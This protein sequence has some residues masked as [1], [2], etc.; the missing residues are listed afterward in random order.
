MNMKPL[1]RLFIFAAV[2][3]ALASCDSQSGEKP[4]NS[5]P[6]NLLN[7]QLQGQPVS[8]V[9]VSYDGADTTS[10]VRY[11]YNKTGQML[12]VTQNDYRRTRKKVKRRRYTV[13]DTLTTEISYT[14]DDKSKLLSTS[15]VSGANPEV[16]ID[17]NG[18]VVREYWS[19]DK[20]Y[21]VDYEY[22]QAGRILRR[23]Q[24]GEGEKPYVFSYRYGPQGRLESYELLKPAGA[25]TVYE[26]DTLGN[27]IQSTEYN[28]KG[29]EGKRL[30]WRYDYDEQGNWTAKYQL[31][32][33]GKAILLA[34]REY[35]YPGPEIDDKAAG[36]AERQQVLQQIERKKHT[37]YV[38][39][40]KDRFSNFRYFASLGT[41]RV[42]IT[43]AGV[44]M[45]I[46]FLG[47]VIYITVSRFRE[48][49]ARNHRWFAFT[50]YPSWE[51][52][53]RRMWMYNKEPYTYMGSIFLAAIASFILSILLM[54]FF[55]ICIWGILWL[56][57]GLL[58]VIVIAAFIGVIAG[59]CGLLF[60]GGE[61]K[62][63]GC[64][65]ILL[66][67]AIVN[68]RIAILDWGKG[69][70]EWG[71]EFF[72]RINMVHWTW[73]FF[74]YYWDVILL[75]IAI[76][77]VLF[78]AIALLCILISL[79]FMGVEAVVSYYYGIRR[80][81]PACGNTKQ[82]AY[83][84]NMEEHPVSLHPGLYGILHQKRYAY[85]KGN[86]ET[87]AG[88]YLYSLPTML[89]N[90]K[91]E[92]TRRCLY[93][94]CGHIINRKNESIV[95]TDL[96]IGIIGHR[97]NGKSFMMYKGLGMLLEE[98]GSQA[99]QV[100]AN[101]NTDIAENYARV[102]EDS[103][104][105]TDQRRHYTAV[106]LLVDV[107]KRP[108]PYHLFFY[109]VAGERFNV[110][111]KQNDNAMDFYRHVQTILF[112]IDPA[113]VDIR[114]L[115]ISSGLG[116]WMKKNATNE[117]YDVNDVLDMLREYLQNVN[118]DPHQVDLIF[119]F[120]KSDTGYFEAAGLD[121]QNI[122]E[123]QIKDFMTGDLGLD[124][125]LNNARPYFGSIGFAA[126]TA[127]G[128]SPE[129]VKTFFHRVLRQRGIDLDKDEREGNVFK[130]A[131]SDLR[132]LFKR[133]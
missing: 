30:Q 11:R 108:Y 89:F 40:I 56:V 12:S 86:K 131:F 93:P 67:G 130:T 55:G 42:M 54:F 5:S 16:N 63:I 25:R 79:I 80:P 8:V 61:H 44:I 35:E 118:R 32:K 71:Q 110:S 51:T 111:D 36:A 76:P 31:G 39:S 120:T 104:P 53:M 49:E 13:I 15:S 88:G 2:L 122:T 3:S 116:E 20:P 113:L 9:E 66:C 18:N 115:N 38:E 106:Q 98:L 10:H 91:G 123:G 129:S 26:C 21:S 43:I 94:D 99:R 85:E 34:S 119:T 114:S 109:D 70:T 75:I 28:K 23:T 103:L 52:G 37:S 6:Y 7:S 117:K 41:N 105:P 96:H 65:S 83:M 62:G 69:L 107:P 64:L 112:V 100:D 48:K 14:Y 22:D 19:A 17:D 82:F 133:S 27:V 132:N 90:G 124:N 68:F 121:H 101:D 95:A 125:V 60:G 84:H 128:R 87:W 127:M 102:E 57:Y 72:D 45:A 4:H 24:T 29:R 46:L 81:C 59:I 47:S 50:G 78:L 33:G 74:T 97:S 58:W 1:S 73:D 77:F 92:L 126:I